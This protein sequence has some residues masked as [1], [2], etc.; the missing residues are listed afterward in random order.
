[1]DVR[2]LLKKLVIVS[3]LCVALVAC[4]DQAGDPGDPGS[5]TG[6]GATV[7]SADDH[8]VSHICKEPTHADRSEF[9][10]IDNSHLIDEYINANPDYF[11]F[12]TAADIPADLVW[13]DGMDLPDLGSPEA[14]KG[15]TYHE[16]VQDFPRTMRLVGPDSNGSFRPF[17]LDYVRLVWARAHPGTEEFQVYPEVAS[18]WAV[19]RDEKKVYIKINPEARFS[20]GMPITTADVTFTMY[21]MKQSFIVAPWYND[22]YTN[23]LNG[24]T[25]YDDHTFAISLPDARPDMAYKA[26]NWT[27]YPR[28]FF[29]ELG[30][31]YPA[32]F[33]WQFVPSSGPYVVCPE[34]IK[35]GRSL[36]IRHIP[37]WWAADNKFQKN[38]FNFDKLRFV[39]IRDTPK[40][41]EA[42]RAGEI[43]RFS[44]QLAEYWYD[45]L[46]DDDPDVAAGYIHKSKFINVHPRPTYGLWINRTKPYLDN[47]D[48]RIGINYAS[49]WQAVAER[50]Y[51]GDAVRMR[52]TADGYGPLTHPTLKARSFDPDKAK[53][54]FAKAGFTEIG[55]DGILRNARGEKLSF[56]L[57]SGWERL[58]DISAI[59]REEAMKAGLELRIEVLDGTAS[60]KKVQEKKHDIQFSAF[61]VGYEMY[62]RYWETSHS[63]NAYEGGAFLEDGSVNPDRKVKTQTNN[64]EVMAVKEID[65]LI[66]RYRT[67]EDLEEMKVISRQLEEALHEEASFVPGFVLPFYRIG[68]HRWLRFPEGFNEMHT[69]S[70]VQFFVSWIDQDMRKETIAAKKA[71][72]KFEPEINVYDQFEEK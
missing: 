19:S 34:D 11:K 2:D 66:Q 56:T 54:H 72:V 39:V 8:K 14:K 15:G 58:K 18:S 71:G 47:K 46:P 50:F 3:T 62:P 69:R 28:H 37:D 44:L 51:R 29:K 43:E 41:F 32:R 55:D 38:R 31:D 26:L 67:S 33:Q 23:T 36:T 9:P 61:A 60:W 13:E 10:P 52:T 16:R 49:N 63:D 30:D 65:D 70:D 6:G 17:I 7:A 35:K 12:A 5:D 42:F 22:N 45:K 59:L 64:L 20:D 24:V 48:V 4:G 53:E 40:S 21:M 57:T 25:V 1:M 27:P 68:H